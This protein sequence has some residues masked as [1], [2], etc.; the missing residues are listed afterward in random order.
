MFTLPPGE[1]SCDPESTCHLLL[2]FVLAVMTTERPRNSRFTAKK[3]TIT[4][5][6]PQGRLVIIGCDRMRTTCVIDSQLGVL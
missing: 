2:L 1:V 3:K 5:A 6:R 4:T